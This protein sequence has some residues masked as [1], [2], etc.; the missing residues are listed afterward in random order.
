MA[1]LSST[2]RV[3]PILLTNFISDAMLDVFIGCEQ[4]QIYLNL[5]ILNQMLQL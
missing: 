1:I 2:E 3:A 4:L 5:I